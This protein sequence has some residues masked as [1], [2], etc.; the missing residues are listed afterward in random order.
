MPGMNR[1]SFEG[2]GEAAQ[3]HAGQSHLN[4]EEV[5]EYEQKKRETR[6]WK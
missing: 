2:G 1:R 6:G 3:P 4:C 5:I